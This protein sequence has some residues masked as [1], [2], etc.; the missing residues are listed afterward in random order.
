MYSRRNIC[1][2]K[3]AFI[4][5]VCI[6][7]YLCIPY[8]SLSIPRY[9]SAYR[10]YEGK[11]SAYLLVYRKVTPAA[12][13]RDQAALNKAM[14]V[15]VT[16]SETPAQVTNE[17]STAAVATAVVPLEPM[18]KEESPFNFMSDHSGLPPLAI[19]ASTNNDANHLSTSMMVTNGASNN[20]DSSSG[21]A[22]D[23]DFTVSTTGCLS[24]TPSNNPAAKKKRKKAKSGK[25]QNYDPPLPSTTVAL[26]VKQALS[27]KIEGLDNASPLQEHSPTHHTGTG[28][29]SNIVT[30]TQNGDAMDVESLHTLTHH[31]GHNSD[32]SLIYNI[33]SGDPYPAPDYWLKHVLEANKALQERRAQ[34]TST[35]EIIRVLCTCH[36]QVEFDLLSTRNGPSGLPINLL[37]CVDIDCDRLGPAVQVKTSLSDLY[38]SLLHTLLDTDNTVAPVD[39]SAYTLSIL[40]QHGECYYPKDHAGDDSPLDGLIKRTCRKD[41]VPLFLLWNGR[42]IRGQAIL[43]GP[44]H[45]PVSLSIRLLTPVDPL[46]DLTAGTSEDGSERPSKIVEYTENFVSIKAKLS[47]TYDLWLTP[48]MTITALAERLKHALGPSLSAYYIDQLTIYLVNR[49]QASSA[50]VEEPV[51]LFPTRTRSGGGG[52]SSAKSVTTKGLSFELLYSEPEL[53]KSGKPKPSSTTTTST[54]DYSQLTIAE[55]LSGRH[56]S[57]HG[58]EL[59]IVDTRK[60]RDESLVPLEINRRN[61]DLNLFIRLEISTLLSHIQSLKTLPLP[62]STASQSQQQGKQAMVC[63]LTGTD[64]TRQNS[65]PSLI[66]AGWPAAIPETIEVSKLAYYLSIVL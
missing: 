56:M 13:A 4:T 46:L 62:V 21:G 26:P 28:C 16:S 52:G 30:S 31:N 51:T 20:N 60:D 22:D 18:V 27:I 35:R 2:F 38:P 59:L 45:V 29:S 66:P 7:S 57:L 5:I 43:S 39:L 63:D 65:D 37:K 9:T 50:K 6:L 42:D 32:P 34:L 25:G 14:G 41:S 44:S 53:T 24:A 47:P 12:I 19:T 23:D 40:N 49:K 55:I 61:T 48:S 11:D 10:A 58:S 36:V 15:V 8:I 1:I 17:A 3:P 54:V 33:L 64:D